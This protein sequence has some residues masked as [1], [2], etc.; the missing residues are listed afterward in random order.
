MTSLILNGAELVSYAYDM[1]EQR[2]VKAVAGEAA[3][4]YH[5][6]GEG[7]LIAETNAATG[8][9][10]REYVWL[11]PPLP[12]PS[13]PKI[14]SQDRF[15]RGVRTV[16]EAPIASFGPD[17]PAANDNNPEDCTDEIAALEA[18]IAD[19]TKRIDRNAARITELGD[20][21]TDKKSRIAN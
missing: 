17:N 13:S 18:D 3:I 9:T 21:A 8:A 16:F 14:D 10:I 19:R 11:G 4:H 2:I 6:D 15:F 1:S 5:Y 12:W 20:L 7:R